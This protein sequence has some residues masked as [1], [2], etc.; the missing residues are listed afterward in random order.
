[1]NKVL[2]KILFT[3]LFCQAPFFYSLHA[4]QSEEKVTVRCSPQLQSILNKILKVPE[5]KALIAS[6]QKEGAIQIAVK[7]TKLSNF[8]GAYWDPD[9]RMICVAMSSKTTEGDLIGSILFELHN[10]SVDSQFE[11]LAGLAIQRKIDKA[12]YVR[13]MEYLEYQNSLN[14][15]KIAEKGIQ[16]GVLPSDSRLPTFTTFQE[17]FSVQ[18]QSGHSDCFGRIYD[19][20]CRANWYPG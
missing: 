11:Y 19:N 17:H 16:L 14:A 20:L 13:S 3:F 15:A 9:Q 4:A 12:T 7:N 8:F 5:A 6:I 10:A 1:M 2:V 18:Q